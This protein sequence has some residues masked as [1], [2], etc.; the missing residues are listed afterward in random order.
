MGDGSDQPAGI[1]MLGGAFLSFHPLH[2]HYGRLVPA[3]RSISRAAPSPIIATDGLEADW[4]RAIQT[5]VVDPDQK[6]CHQTARSHCV[7]QLASSNSFS[8]ATLTT[9]K[10]HLARAPH[11]VQISLLIIESNHTH[12]QQA[13]SCLDQ[14]AHRCLPSTPKSL[15]DQPA[16]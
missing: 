15:T 11:P 4:P 7:C 16:A 10:K 2:L 13:R 14:P 12:A 3:H 9:K 8:G 5:S 1:K 6:H